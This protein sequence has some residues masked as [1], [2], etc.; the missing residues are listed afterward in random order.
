MLKR[1]HVVCLASLIKLA[2]IT[3]FHI[4]FWNKYQGPRSSGY[5]GGNCTRQFWARGACT[6]QFSAISVLICTFS[7]FFLT[8]S[9]FSKICCENVPFMTKMSLSSIHHLLATS[10]L[11]PSIETHYEGPVME[12]G[13][14]IC[15]K[16]Y[17]YCWL[18]FIENFWKIEKGYV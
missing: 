6:R 11:H 7:D 8:L 13:T 14:Y 16:L 10:F 17:W 2:A 18:C 3:L 15:Q 5:R 4:Q 12:K 9:S 1:K